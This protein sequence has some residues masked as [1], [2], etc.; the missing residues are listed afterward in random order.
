MKSPYDFFKTDKDLETGKGVELDY[1]AFS[2]TIHRAG[3]QNAKFASVTMAKMAPHRR[4]L[5]SGSLDE[6]VGRRLMAEIYA[7]SVI[8]GWKNVVDEAGKPLPF[9]KENC[10]KLLLDLPEFFSDIQEQAQN[11]ANFRA[12]ALEKEAKNSVT[13]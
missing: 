2:I 9:T 1:G 10:V 8:I 6:D 3:G 11:M 4:K 5:Q 13:S 12:E 7:E